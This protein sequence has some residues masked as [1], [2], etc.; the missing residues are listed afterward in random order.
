MVDGGGGVSDTPGSSTPSGHAE[1]PTTLLP[2]GNST[3]QAMP[4]VG[5]NAQREC[6]FL[7]AW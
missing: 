4:A 5:D 2:S 3:E 7:R 1:A 6:Y